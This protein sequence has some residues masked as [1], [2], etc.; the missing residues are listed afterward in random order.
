VRNQFAT[1]IEKELRMLEEYVLS[2]EVSDDVGENLIANVLGPKAEFSRF[3]P[4][5]VGDTVTG[6]IAGRAQGF[7]DAGS[8]V[9]SDVGF[10]AGFNTRIDTGATTSEPP[11]DDPPPIDVRPS[12]QPR[13]AGGE[14]DL[15]V[16]DGRTLILDGDRDS[17][18]I[19]PMADDS[20]HPTN[21]PSREVEPGLHDAPTLILDHRRPHRRKQH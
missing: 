15:D 14:R 17:R 1:E 19:E 9:G 16:H 7:G 21:P 8:G 3:S 20:L 18:Q 4:R 12:P 5:P 2:D 6:G 11:F 10:E 13:G